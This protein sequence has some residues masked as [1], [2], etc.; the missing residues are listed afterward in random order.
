MVLWASS[1]IA[2]KFAFR[3]F[4]PW[5]VIF[6]RMVVASLCFAPFLKGLSTSFRMKDLKLM[7]F[8]AVCEPGLYF[9]FEAKALTYTSASQAGMITAMLPLMVAAAAAAVLKERLTKRM[10]LGFA[11][12]VVGALWLSVISESDAHAPNPMLGNFLE[13][14]AM[15]CATG[16]MICC[17]RLSARYG[18]WFLTAVQSLVGA[19]FYLPLLLLP[20]T[21]LP[22]SFP[23]LPTA[24]IIYLGSA[25][26]LLAYGLY[27]YGLSRL[28]AGQSSAFINLIPVITVLLG[29]LILGEE[30]TGWQY[31]ASAVVML[32]V[33]VSQESAGR[34][35][36]LPS[37]TL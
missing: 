21:Q 16:Y 2:L 13:F 19:V 27:N 34:E 1:F 11:M 3:H 35:S 20:S 23:P 33:L 17:K 4:D 12:A 36:P 26:T 14:M 6:G 32:G 37:S 30:F 22:T 25:V 5:V 7:V 15:V 29:H 18:S 28:P 31:A 8:M 9:V 24:S 10:V